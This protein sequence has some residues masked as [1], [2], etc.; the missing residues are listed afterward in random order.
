MLFT[1][2]NLGICH[3]SA[4]PGRSSSF[5]PLV[6][7]VARRTVKTVHPRFSC[8]FVCFV[9]PNA[10]STLLGCLLFAICLTGC[11]PSANPAPGPSATNSQLSTLNS[12]LPAPIARLHWLG[13]KQLAAETNATNFMAIWNLPESAR[14]EAQ[15]LD[16][17]ATA[18]WRLL[19]GVAPLSNAPS[20][21]LRP[22]LDDLMQCES[23]LEVTGDTNHPTEFV[24]AIRLPAARAALWE[25]NL[26][27][28]LKS[29]SQH[30]PLLGGDGGGLVHGEGT[31]GSRAGSDALPPTLNSQPSTESSSDFILHT[32]SFTLELSRSGDWTLLSVQTPSPHPMGRGQGEGLAASPTPN[33]QLPSANPTLNPQLS[34]HSSG[35]QLGTRN[36]ELGTQLLASFRSRIAR[37]HAPYPAR[38]TNCWI[39][40]HVASQVISRWLG[41]P[42]GSS[43]VP[44]LVLTL[45]G[46]GDAVR[47]LITARFENRSLNV[48]PPWQIPTNLIHDPLVAFTAARNLRA[49]A[50]LVGCAGTMGGAPLPEQFFS[51]AQASPFETFAA[52][53]TADATNQ[54]GRWAASFLPLFTAALGTNASSH[55]ETLTNGVG[56]TWQG[57]P[58]LQPWARVAEGASGPMIVA[59]MVPL[60]RTNKPAPAALLAQVTTPANLLYYDW[61][62]TGPRIESWFFIGQ[63][64][65]LELKKAQLAPDSAAGSWLVALSTR[66]GNSATSVALTQPGELTLTRRGTLG[67]TGLELQLLADWLESPQ[68][69]VGFNT[70][71]TPPRPPIRVQRH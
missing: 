54:F 50:A 56:Y 57:T 12:Q 59:G 61:E 47:T 71:L 15:T 24:L 8:H 67:F 1:T 10:F 31:S 41:L 27:V 70:L 45:N 5:V 29:L 46:D 52:F 26:P 53:P 28:I 49:L 20:A 4:H 18:P 48:G 62:I 37:D 25:T 11:S 23:Y 13:K 35:Q 9:V 3:G 32:S 65:R 17:L 51:W 14:L 36:V 55:V 69:P 33:S 16:K 6:L 58:F 21:L 22:L 34:T 42:V 38:A 7:S 19:P 39:E 43:S 44:Q 60:L 68:F 63:T 64:F 40:A 2:D 66:L 30:A